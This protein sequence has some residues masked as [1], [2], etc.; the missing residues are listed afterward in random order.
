[1]KH[2]PLF[3]LFLAVSCAAPEGAY[4]FYDEPAYAEKERQ[5]PI[6]TEQAATLFARNYFEQ[7]PYAEKVTAHIDVLFRKKYIVSPTMLLHNT[8]FG[9]CFLTPDNYW[10]DGKTGKLKKN[11]REILY[12]R[13]VGRADANGVSIF[14][15]GTFIKT[16]MRDS[17]LN[18]P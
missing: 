2:I 4:V 15:E 8:K 16:Y 3:L 9:A 11:K 12:L 5:L 6:S 14:R 17:L 1:M 10:V 18:T 7:H 13:R